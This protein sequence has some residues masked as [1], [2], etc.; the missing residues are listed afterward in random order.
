MVSDASRCHQNHVGYII[1]SRPRKPPVAIIY[2]FAMVFEVELGGHGADQRGS[3]RKT[4]RWD[5][6]TSPKEVLFGWFRRRE[7]DT[8]E[9][10]SVKQTIFAS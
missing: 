3:D 4:E 7:I 6:S 9:S 8:L 1:K 10:K 5:R 2:L